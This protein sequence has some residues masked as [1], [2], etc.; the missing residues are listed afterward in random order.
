MSEQ[1]TLRVG[2]TVPHFEM[3]T[4]DP[5]AGEFGKFSLEEAKRILRTT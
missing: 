2:Q 3:D 4:Y 5:A 1:I